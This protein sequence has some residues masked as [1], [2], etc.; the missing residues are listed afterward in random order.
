[1]AFTSTDPKNNPIVQEYLL[2][3]LSSHRKGR[4]RQPDEILADTDQVLTMNNER[5]TVPEIIFRPDDIGM[6]Y[7]FHDRPLT[8]TRFGP[9]GHCNHDCDFHIFTPW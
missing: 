5:F 7:G 1:M 6:F 9:V 8:A 4:I 3:D 2:P